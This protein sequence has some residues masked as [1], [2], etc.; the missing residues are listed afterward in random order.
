LK[1]TITRKNGQKEDVER[2]IKYFINDGIVL[3]FNRIGFVTQ[4]YGRMG[5]LGTY[6]DR[7][8][9]MKEACDKLIKKYPEYGYLKTRKRGMCEVG[10]RKIHAFTK[11]N[12]KK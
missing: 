7:L 11:K 1:L 4:Y 2:S 9:P 6:E 5:G 10:L 3:R 8:K 12:I